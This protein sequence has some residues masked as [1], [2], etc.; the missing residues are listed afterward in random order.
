MGE[1]MKIQELF[2]GKRPRHRI[3]DLSKGDRVRV[4]GPKGRTGTVVD[5]N[6]GWRGRHGAP[7]TR[8][9]IGVQFDD[10]KQGDVNSK[11]HLDDVEKIDED[12]T[13]NPV[14]AKLTK[15]LQ[16]YADGHEVMGNQTVHGGKGSIEQKLAKKLLG[17][18]QG[19]TSIA[20]LVK[21]KKEAKAAAEK[22]WERQRA[23]DPLGTNARLE[24]LSFEAGAYDR[25][26]SGIKA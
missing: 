14:V 20:D 13:E 24:K 4:G 26:L 17:L 12:L 9:F 23:K 21:L 16:K 6:P 2:E 25:L 22:A 10:M 15:R 5:T 3:E 11:V 8:P 18:L 7:G 19:G 1:A